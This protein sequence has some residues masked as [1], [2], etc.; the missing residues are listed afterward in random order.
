MRVMNWNIEWAS[1]RSP[2]GRAIAGILGKRDPQILCLT[3][4]PLDLVPSGGHVI[5]S[6]SDYGYTHPGN[7]RK[8][9]LW[10]KTPW[11]SVDDE[12]NALLPGGRFVMGVTQGIRFLGVC[13][14]WRDAHVRTG[15]RDRRPWEDHLAYLGGLKSVI[16]SRA[17]SPLPLCLLGDF[18]QRIPRKR[19]PVYVADR[20][21][22]SLS[23]V[24]RVATAGI[25]DEAGKLLID[26]IAIS[27]GLAVRD[28]DILPKMT[29]DGQRLSD[30]SGVIANVE[31]RC[32]QTNS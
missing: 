14:P 8:V 23:E 12:G 13:I 27:P 26:H 31:S 25:V 20:L 4:A 17:S 15:R 16:D 19:T 29:D 22:D 2:R 7:R 3:E 30:H 9:I 21:S 1:T 11:E 6:H 5:A 32:G 24:L 18:N 28:I 10:S